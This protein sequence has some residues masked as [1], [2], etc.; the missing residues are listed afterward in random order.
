MIIIG[1][2]LL[3]QRNTRKSENIL[4][5]KEYACEQLGMEYIEEVVS[6]GLYSIRTDEYCAKDNIIYPVIMKCKG[7]GCKVY[8]V[9]GK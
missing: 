7:L 5:A 9:G 6:D 2:I 4:K 1:V 8:L 3:S